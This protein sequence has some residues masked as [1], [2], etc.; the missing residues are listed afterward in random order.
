MLSFGRKKKSSSALGVGATP[1]QPVA[2]PVIPPEPSP[3]V[4]R[5][6]EEEF[7]EEDSALKREHFERLYVGSSP[8]LVYETFC[9]FVW[10]E[11]AGVGEVEILKDGST[12]G[13]RSLEVGMKK[14]NV[15]GFEEEVIK[16]LPA[17][18]V[19]IRITDG[20]AAGGLLLKARV[21]FKPAGSEGTDCQVI[22]T[23]WWTPD[24]MLAGMMY[25]LMLKGFCSLALYRLEQKLANVE[26][27]TMV[28]QQQE[29]TAAAEE[30]EETN[31]PETMALDGEMPKLQWA[32]RR[33]TGYEGNLTSEQQQAL[34]Q[35]EQE[36]RKNDP[37]TWRL[38]ELH[39]DGSTRI[40]LRFLRAECSGKQRK[41]NVDLSKVRLAST[42]KFRQEIDADGMLT[43]APEGFDVFT[44]QGNEFAVPDREG[45]LAVFSRVGLMSVCLDTKL[46]TDE[47]W[48]RSLTCVSERRMQVLRENSKR[49]GYEVS[50]QV[51][52]YDVRGIGF[53]S[54]KIIPFA[55]IINDTA[56]KHYPEFV[57]QIIVCFAPAIFTTLFATIKGFLDPITASKVRVFGTSKSEVDKMKLLLRSL[58]DP[59]QLPK[60]FGG[61]STTN[62]VGYPSLYKGEKFAVE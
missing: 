30:E 60:E 49:I 48:K 16:V 34:A 53:A 26:L 46:L 35:L 55:K 9:E 4:I 7:P 10:R 25:T 2:V 32:A 39:P 11:N 58:V 38:C 6:V 5:Q 1:A 57:D 59:N 13:K 37:E 15:G 56:S 3:E 41:F 19:E 36:L 62:V 20:A 18:Q 40:M 8:T 47:Q 42:L 23:I 17:K 24:S 50:A 27:S 61:D 29:Q 44:A 45:R 43:K 51:M 52:V 54:R 22:W 21:L 31:E 14:R 12:A 28:Q 33:Q